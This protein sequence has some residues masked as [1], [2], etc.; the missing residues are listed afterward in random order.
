MVKVGWKT[1]A[2]IQGT[3]SRLPKGKFWNQAIQRRI[4]KS[5]ILDRGKF[6]TK[7]GF[8]R[9]HL[10]NLIRFRRDGQGFTV[11]ELG[12]GRFPIV[13]L[14]M[15]LCGAEQ[16]I[17]LD[18]T[19]LLRNDTVRDTL[20]MYHAHLAEGNLPEARP[21]RVERFREVISAN[22]TPLGI[23]T[24]RQF[25]I[26]TFVGDARHTALPWH[27]FD[28]LAS[29]TTLEHIPGSTLAGILTHFRDLAR[30]DAVMSHFIDM[31]DHYA[32]W[33][34]S[35]TVYNFMRYSEQDWRWFNNS[36]LYQNRL[37]VCD[38][39]RIHA[40]AAWEIV[41]ERAAPGSRR[42][43]GTVPLAGEFRGYA[44]RDLL[45]P[46]CWMV[47]HPCSAAAGEKLTLAAIEKLLKF[48]IPR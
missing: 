43:F 40:Q 32:E 24:L 1:K 47:S 19:R 14:Y 6:Q 41:L 37:R 46:T 38:Y 12:T 16:V 29:N 21:E 20:L 9:E 25:N 18:I 8:A 23:D 45:V 13:P 7:L 10:R 15:F 36:L 26:E 35:I 39:R 33:D 2:F 17:S 5:L 11:L 22:A 48:E 34:R 3:L 4:T 28:L 27:S 42:E 30:P 31:R 44:E